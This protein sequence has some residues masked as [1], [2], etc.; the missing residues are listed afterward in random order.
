MSWGWLLLL[1][2]PQLVLELDR[3]WRESPNWNTD[4]TQGLMKKLLIDETKTLIHMGFIT[5]LVQTQ[6]ISYI[7]ET[8]LCGVGK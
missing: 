2:F 5:V 7:L 1:N 3:S 4:S 6:G 8:D